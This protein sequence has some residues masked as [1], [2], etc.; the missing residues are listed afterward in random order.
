[1]PSSQETLLSPSTIW[2]FGRPL[3]DLTINL[4]PLENF[5]TAETGGEDAGE[6]ANTPPRLG[7]NNFLLE[8]FTRGQDPRLARI[9]GFSFEANYYDMA[10]PVIF[11]VHGDGIDAE[12]PETRVPRETAATSP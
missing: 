10:R 1:M 12:G 5:P 6:A 8:Q 9:Y 7:A 2:L 4:R 11:L 3:A